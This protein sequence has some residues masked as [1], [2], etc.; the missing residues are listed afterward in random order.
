MGKENKDNKNEERRG[1]KKLVITKKSSRIS[2]RTCPVALPALELPSGSGCQE[3]EYDEDALHER[4]MECRSMVK[5]S[6]ASAS[7]DLS[8]EEESTTVIRT[9]RR[10]VREERG[11]GQP[12]EYQP[13]SPSPPID[14]AL[15]GA[16]SIEEFK[17][18]MAGEFLAL[19]GTLDH[20]LKEVSRV[21][22]RMGEVDE[23]LRLGKTR[24]QAL[25]ERSIAQTG[26]PPPNPTTP[27]GAPPSTSKPGKPSANPWGSGPGV[28]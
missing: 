23:E 1:D 14:P 3:E 15:W 13:R 9:K 4:L 5:P 19:R 20:I 16:T 12:S 7:H 26:A 18:W 28:L 27:M 8:S 2:K 25:Q 11:I 24:L 22:K 10:R 21:G 6:I 17:S